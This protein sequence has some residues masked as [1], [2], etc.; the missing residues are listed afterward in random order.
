MGMTEKAPV[1]R[2]DLFEFQFLSE[3]A[4]SPDGRY[5]AY[6]VSQADR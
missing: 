6:V 2:E 4:L 1:K 5:A 3:A